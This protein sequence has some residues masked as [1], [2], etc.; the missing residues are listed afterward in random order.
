MKA[1]IQR[2]K[3]SERIN[4]WIVA[5]C[6]VLLAV[7]GLG[8]F[9]PSFFWL[10]NIFGSPQLA[11]MIHPFIGVVMF[12]G[13]FIQFFRYWHHNF[14]DKND[15]RWMLSVKTILAGGEVGDTGK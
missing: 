8:F 10:T 5:G 9:Y 15:I 14:L 12:V 6:F 11:R 4:H 13:F 7:S 2:Y 1:L 3:R